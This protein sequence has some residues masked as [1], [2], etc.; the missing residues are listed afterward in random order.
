MQIY[1]VLYDDA[2]AGK[3]ISFQ[4]ETIFKSLLNTIKILFRFSKGS[5]FDKL[6]FQECIYDPLIKIVKIFVEEEALLDSLTSRT[7]NKASGIVKISNVDS[8]Y[9]LLIYTIGILK[10][11]SM[12]AIQN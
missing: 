9:D 10:N 7:L 3:G 5:E 11:S 12:V 6:Y 1:F 4:F 8:I 2:K